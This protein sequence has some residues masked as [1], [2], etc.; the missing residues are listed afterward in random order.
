MNAETGNTRVVRRADGGMPVEAMAVPMAATMMVVTHTVNY[1]VAPTVV[2]MAEQMAA[3]SS[4][5]W[6]VTTP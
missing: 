6:A 5:I 2:P 4:S 1:S 3:I